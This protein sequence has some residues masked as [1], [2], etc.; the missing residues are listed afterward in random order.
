MVYNS[1][2][3]ANKILQKG[4]QS[5]GGELI[6]NLK[7]QKLLYYMQGFHLA[8]FDT[9]LF[10]DDIFAWQYGPVLPEVY[11]RYKAN[12]NK[13]IEPVGEVIVLEEKEE[14]LFDEVF[15]VYGEF[16]AIGL[17]NLTHEEDPWKNT[18]IGEKILKD[19]MTEFFKTRIV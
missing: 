12:G 4:A 3:I 5:D 6:S 19:K 13:G 16:S 7:L 8:V 14:K 18:P 10:D 15:S 1:F 2:D 9:P 17:M 11:Y